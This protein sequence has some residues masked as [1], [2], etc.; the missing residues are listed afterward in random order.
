VEYDRLEKQWHQ[1]LFPSLRPASEQDVRMLEEW[2]DQ[3][4][5]AFAIKGGTA[6]MDMRDA[7]YCLQIYNVGLNELYRQTAI[8]SRHRARVLDSVPLPPAANR[9]RCVSRCG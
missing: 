4:L 1:V 3:Q 6:G 2:L 9:S 7:A 5:A 8:S